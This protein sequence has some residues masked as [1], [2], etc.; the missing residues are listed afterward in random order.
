MEAL[1]KL[2]IQWAAIRDQD[3]AQLNAELVKAGKQPIN[4]DKPASSHAAEAGDGDDE[5]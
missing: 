1:K 2:E 5:P 3:I 4:P